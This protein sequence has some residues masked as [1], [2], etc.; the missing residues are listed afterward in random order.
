[1]ILKYSEVVSTQRNQSYN[2]NEKLLAFML[3]CQG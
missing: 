3:G 2:S 1:M